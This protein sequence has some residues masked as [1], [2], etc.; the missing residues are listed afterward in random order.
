M[1]TS[2]KASGQLQAKQ[3]L[4]Q[5]KTLGRGGRF[6]QQATVLWSSDSDDDDFESSPSK[7]MKKTTSSKS[8]HTGTDLTAKVLHFSP[9]KVKT[10]CLFPPEEEQAVK[11]KA[12]QCNFILRPSPV[13]AEK[14]I[15]SGL[16]SGKVSRRS[17]QTGRDVR[18]PVQTGRDM[19]GPAVIGSSV[20]EAT[21]ES[22]SE[23]VEHMHCSTGKQGKC[24][25]RLVKSKAIEQTGNVAHSLALGPMERRKRTFLTN[26]RSSS[27]LT[28]SETESDSDFDLPKV[29][30]HNLISGKQT[31]VKATQ[32]ESLAQREDTG[33]EAKS[34][35]ITAA[36]F[37]GI[38]K[39][40]DDLSDYIL[41][42]RELAE[43]D[44]FGATSD[45][46]N[47][48]KGKTSDHNV[49]CAHS[50]VQ[51]LEGQGAGQRTAHEKPAVVFPKARDS[52]QVLFSDEDD[53][54]CE[55][56]DPLLPLPDVKNTFTASLP[57][58]MGGQ[59]GAQLV[60]GSRGID[61]SSL[62]A[63]YHSEEV[64]QKAEKATPTVFKHREAPNG[65]VSCHVTTHS[66]K[67]AATGLPPAV[68]SLVAPHASVTLGPS[69]PQGLGS[70]HAVGASHPTVD[71]QATSQMSGKVNSDASSPSVPIPQQKPEVA[72]AS[73][74]A[75][76]R[77]SFS[78]LLPEGRTSNDASHSTALSSVQKAVTQSDSDSDMSSDD[79]SIAIDPLGGLLSDKLK[80]QKQQQVPTKTAQG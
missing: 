58:A 10:F 35:D 24:K 80:L 34:M 64:A 8:S 33:K 52:Y 78:I 23:G 76:V 72:P 61:T 45:E 7:D 12:R 25:E 6:R 47:G 40:S 1:V 16:A 55:Q 65:S 39:D 57:D 56:E 53:E 77:T 4:S 42:E 54:E 20:E 13:P 18:G 9:G 71:A 41:S 31:V 22:L 2:S 60:K 73:E 17:V 50:S 79:T 11:K 30:T 48:C 51:A 14:W 38:D 75:S 69:E 37:S 3:S 26:Q 59:C 63:S 29:S 66:D 44:D 46:D 74:P 70:T 67:E 62:V 43:F 21:T 5:E 19:R 68:P 15:S 32:C 36:L 27:T 49:D 28:L